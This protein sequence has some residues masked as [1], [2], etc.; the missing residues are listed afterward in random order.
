DQPYDQR[1]HPD[2]DSTKEE[3]EK[4]PGS[5]REPERGEP[6]RDTRHDRH[7]QQDDR[8]CAWISRKEVPSRPLPPQAQN[9]GRHRRDRRRDGEHPLPAGTDGTRQQD[10]C[11]EVSAG[12]GGFAGD[13][14]EPVGE[15]PPPRDRRRH[16]A[17]ATTRMAKRSSGSATDLP[18]TSTL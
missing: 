9:D 6:N 15:D 8:K 10:A 1:E 12:R 2:F 14:H 4:G 5:E 13:A 3:V 11:G 7:G 17:L 18:S 16:V